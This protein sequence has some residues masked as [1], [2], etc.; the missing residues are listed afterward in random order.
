LVLIVH[1]WYAVNT[2]KLCPIGWHVP[3]DNELHT[4]ISYL[5]PNAQLINGIES[6][7]AGGK[8]KETGTEHWH[9]PNAGATNEVSFAALPG[10]WR[11]FNGKFYYVKDDCRFWSSTESTSVKAWCRSILYSSGSI[12]RYENEKKNGFS[13]RCIKD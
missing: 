6:S 11:Y 9:S 3:N 2:G 8:L 1:L 5:D 13:M 12:A 7:L 4:L 10:G